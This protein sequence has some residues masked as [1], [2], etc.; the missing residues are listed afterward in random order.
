[1]RRTMPGCGDKGE[2]SHAGDA[3]TWP[4]TDRPASPSGSRPGVCAVRGLI[5][6]ASVCP[7]PAAG[8]G[9]P[10]AVGAPRGGGCRCARGWG[11][12]RGVWRPTPAG[13]LPQVER[14]LPCGP[15]GESQGLPGD[16]KQDLVTSRTKQSGF[17]AGAVLTRSHC[18][19]DATLVLEAMLFC[20]STL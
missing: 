18:I 3:A 16:P 14:P 9:P 13:L 8:P 11:A 2:A 5:N 7:T 10:A 12:A 19:Q 20:K 15:W 17:R 1:M 4:R 6:H